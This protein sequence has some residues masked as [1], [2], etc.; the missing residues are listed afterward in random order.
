MGKEEGDKLISQLT[1]Y[2]TVKKLPKELQSQLF[3]SNIKLKWNNQTHSYIS[4]GSIGVAGIGTKMI[5]KEATGTIEIRKRK[6]GD[7]LNMYI[8]FDPMH[9]YFF[10]Y[11]QGQMQVASSNPD[12]NNIISTLKDDK[13]SEKTDK[14][15]FSFVTADPNAR[16]IFLKR[17]NG[18]N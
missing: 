15:K 2:G 10:T 18:D 14:G 17:V 1:L 4:E 7:Q 12:F 8:E 13:R 16:R 6:Q 9:W 3:L 5:N 11:Y